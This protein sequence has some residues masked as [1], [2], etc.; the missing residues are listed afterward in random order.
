MLQTNHESLLFDVCGYISV[1][2]SHWLILWVCCPYDSN[3]KKKSKIINKLGSYFFPKKNLQNSDTVL[4]TNIDD[5][6]E[7]D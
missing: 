7:N 3:D 2:H 6:D 5:D 1:C 4:A